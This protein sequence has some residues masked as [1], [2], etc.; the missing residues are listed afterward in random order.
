MKAKLFLAAGLSACVLLSGCGEGANENAISKVPEGSVV[1]GAAS[2]SVISESTVSSAESS[3]TESSKAVS[4]SSKAESPEVSVPQKPD[5][6]VPTAK[7]DENSKIVDTANKTM[8][9]SFTTD[10]PFRSDIKY[11]LRIYFADSHNSESELR[12]DE[13]FDTSRTSL[14]FKLHEGNNYYDIQFRTDEKEGD[15][16]NQIYQDLGQATVTP[17]NGGGNGGWNSGNGGL[18]SNVQKH[19]I[20]FFTM[21]G[22]VNGAQFEIF[23]AVP[24]YSQ[25]NSLLCQG[26]QPDTINVDI[27]LNCPYCGTRS[28]CRTCSYS[29][30]ESEGNPVTLKCDNGNCRLHRNPQGTFICSRID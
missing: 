28:Y 30:N 6:E 29:Y 20:S 12:Y 16:S 24:D 22:A 5:Y 23:E 8:T 18:P 4:S 25:V 1:E 15:R 11:Y 27:Y 3:D 9:V 13:P 14:T 17:T 10:I 7:L 26:I 2:S 21:Q 19:N